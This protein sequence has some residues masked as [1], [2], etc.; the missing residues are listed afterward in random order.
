MIAE[1]RSAEFEGEKSRE[2]YFL[3][4]IFLAASA[5]ICDR[6]RLP[7]T[8]PS[9]RATPDALSSVH[10]CVRPAASLFPSTP[11]LKPS[12]LAL[13][14]SFGI[15]HSWIPGRT[16]PQAKPNTSHRCVAAARFCADF[17]VLWHTP[18]RIQEA[19]GCR[20]RGPDKRPTPDA[21]G[22]K[23]LLSRPHS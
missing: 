12:A 15:G 21:R 8:H 5:S 18:P 13:S 11:R 9:L 23:R 3:A 16:I 10:P 7:A 19:C 14:L 2:R 4:L 20:T 17:G 22:W 6:F 1:R